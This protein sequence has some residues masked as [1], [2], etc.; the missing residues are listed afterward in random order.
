MRVKSAIVVLFLFIWTSLLFSQLKI[1]EKD[2]PLKYKEFLKLTQYIIQEREKDAFLQLTSDRDRDIF[3]EAFW[4]QRDP[5][6][7]TPE[8]EFRE[9]HL[10]RFEYVNKFYKR[11]TPREG[12]MTDQGRFYIILGP[13]NSIERFYGTLGIHPCEVWS[14]YGDPEKGLPSQFNLVFYQK[15]GAGEFKL[16]DPLVDGPAALI[17][18]SLGY[19]MEDY[20]GLYDRLMELAPTLANAA[21]SLIPGEIPYNYM[22]SPRNSIL[23]AEIIESPKK[24][25]NPAY[26]THFLTYKGIVS[27]EQMTN[28]VDSETSTALIPD[29]LTGMNFLHFSI[30]PKTLSVN[31]Y[32]PKDQYYCSLSLA[33][34]LR[35]K[36][37]VIFQ[38]SKDFPLYFDS[39]ELDKIK[40]NGISIEDS[41]PVIEGDYELIIL[42]QNSIGKEF[43]IFENDISVS[44]SSETPQIFG[45]FLGYKLQD[46]QSDVHIPFKM[47]DKK[48]IVD[49]KKT[50]S[51]L[52]GVSFVFNLTN[53]SESLWN[54][55]RVRVAVSG[56][57]KEAPLQKSFIMR[58]RDYNYNK[59]MSIPYSFPPRE[60]TPDYYEIKVM[61]VDKDEKVIDEKKA[62]FIV[63]QAEAV[64]HPFANAKALPSSGNFLFYYMLANQYSKVKAREKAEENYEKAYSLN[65]GYKKGAMEYANFLLSVDKFD[66]S[67]AL[68]ET[69]KEDESLKFEYYLLKGRAYMGKGLYDQA[70]ESFLE[71]NKIYN[72]DTRLLNAIGMCYYQTQ[73]KEKALEALGASL[74]LN[75]AQEDIKKLV[76]KIKKG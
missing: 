14:Y 41:F 4:K 73:Q 67:L 68:L 74:R 55:G 75:P 17:V 61:L 22:P 33:V 36:G 11:G 27:T 28:F 44:E 62:N 46:Y 71:G 19:G 8:N 6:P 7:G 58:L 31:Y 63:S 53:V 10:K 35:A 50:F 72:S 38:Y 20:E 43:S 2:L 5:T 26:A 52:E 48:L 30:A 29:P 42:L 54:E 49:P 47:V 60:L 23:L 69:L 1:K 39:N 56:L 65:P 64:S 34:S 76:E 51:I 9:E 24:D 3:I 25:I 70:I 37:D 18:D 59:I 21:I 57:K 16:Y 40:A 12:W 32:D 66:K 15:G 45:P 13:P